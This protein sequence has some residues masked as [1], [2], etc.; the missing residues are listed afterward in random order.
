MEHFCCV[1]VSGDVHL[2]AV[3]KLQELQLATTTTA[4]KI[5]RI[6]NCG[7]ATVKM[8]AA[9]MDLEMTMSTM[10]SCGVDVGTI[11]HSRYVF[12]KIQINYY[13]SNENV[14]YGIA[15]EEYKL[16]FNCLKEISFSFQLL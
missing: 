7:L 16:V 1:G 13:T 12:Q 10:V 9:G 4:K 15:N 14:F 2:A 8:K 5:E 11:G 6:V 3:Q